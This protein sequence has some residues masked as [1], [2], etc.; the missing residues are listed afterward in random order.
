MTALVLKPGSDRRLRAGHPWIYRSEIADLEGDWAADEAVTVVDG[1]GHFLGRGFYNPRPAIAC[2]LL[3]RRDE[4]VDGAFF[5]RRL[6]AAL[7]YRQAASLVAE[8]Y[9]LCWSEADGLPGLV[10]DRYGPASVVQPLTLGMER[11]LPWI[12]EALGQL[13]PRR[14]IYRVDDPTAARIEGFAPRR[15]WLGAGGGEGMETVVSEGECRFAVSFG[16]GQ[17]T[18]LYLDQRDNRRLVAAHAAGRRVLDAFCYMGAFACQALK[19]GAGEALLLD[20]SA[21]ALAGAARNLALNGLAGRATVR[22]GNTFDELRGL[23]A[24]R[25]RFGLV[26]LDPPPFT[27]RKEA[28]EAA[29][30]GYKEINLRGLRLL[31]PD[32]VL[33][34]FSCSHH[35]T[36]AHF[37]EICRGAA[38]DAGIVVRVLATLGQ[39]RDHPVLLSVPE[40]RYLT[41]LLLQRL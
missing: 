15:G 41:G 23:E 37:E 5:L 26:V 38:G 33:A 12:A 10:V 24:R 7:G 21:E 30:R 35:V 16:A 28:V 32:G 9:R 19:A 13:F 4:P 6:R 3:T 2:R 20:S 29:A 34:T 17:K 36:P 31:E 25:E 39:S 11:A 1:H 18:G 27:R 40:S 14:P 22:E 8:A